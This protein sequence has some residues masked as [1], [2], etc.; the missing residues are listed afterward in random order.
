MK[1]IAVLGA[2]GFIGSRTIEILK[3]ESEYNIYPIIRSTSK[4]YL[5]SRLGLN[6]GIADATNYSELCSVFDRC[7]TVIHAILGRP[8]IIQ[9]SIVAAYQAAQKMGVRRLVY[10]STA[11]VHGLN[12]LSGTDENSPL[13]IRHPLAY[14]NAKVK[15]ERK[16]LE[17]RDRGSTEVVILRPSIVFG[18]GDI[19]VTAFA[20]SLILGKAFLVNGGQG[21]CNSIYVDNLVQAIK[22]AITAPHADRQAFLVAD[23]ERVVWADV[24]R[25]IAEALRFNFDLI[26]SIECYNDKFTVKER[27]LEILRSSEL[28]YQMQHFLLR[29]SPAVANQQSQ[30][31][32]VLT[33]QMASLYQCQYKFSIEKAKI[34]LGYEPAISFSQAIQDTANWLSAQIKP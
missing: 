31:Q 21:I 32:L 27:I 28:L 9:K 30:P 13:H 24:Y 33:S 8:W 1:K 22:L 16:L 34:V 6:Y 29:S 14:C 23:S 3:P 5:I 4:I 11:A 10:L 2:S 15:A 19:W 25:P 12:I 7:D 17:L 20:N 26:P 18:C